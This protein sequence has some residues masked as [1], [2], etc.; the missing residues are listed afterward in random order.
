MSKVG[1]RLNSCREINSNQRKFDKDFNYL[2]Y[3][4]GSA[5]IVGEILKGANNVGRIKKR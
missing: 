5:A 2:H 3:S 1:L 4:D